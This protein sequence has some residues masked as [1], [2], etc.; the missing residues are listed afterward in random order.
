MN[1]LLVDELGQRSLDGTYL[2]VEQLELSQGVKSRQVIHALIQQVAEMFPTA[3]WGYWER[4]DRP[5]KQLRI[6]SRT[7]LL[8]EEVSV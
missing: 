7:Q 6:Y 3:H 8:K 2:Y 1:V 4:R 5:R